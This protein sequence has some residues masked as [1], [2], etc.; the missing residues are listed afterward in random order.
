LDKTSLQLTSIKEENVAE[1]VSRTKESTA[2]IFDDKLT[3]GAV[4]ATPDSPLT[5]AEAEDLRDSFALNMAVKKTSRN[6]FF[7]DVFFCDSVVSHKRNKSC[8]VRT[9]TFI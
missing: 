3:P 9:S 8:P 5:S 2:V 4:A 7:F 6:D 1:Q